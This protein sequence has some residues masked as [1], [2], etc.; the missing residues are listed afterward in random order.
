LHGVV[1]CVQAP[2][3][4]HD[5][6][7]VCTPPVHDGVPHDVD[8]VGYWQVVAT[9]LQVLSHAAPVP[10][11]ARAGWFEPTEFAWT[12]P[13]TVTQSPSAPVT[14]QAW[15]ELPHGELQQ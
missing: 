15:H 11:A 4:L 5:P 3:P 14:S 10:Q 6:R 13:V 8:P 12:V 2:L 1:V 7:F 9:P